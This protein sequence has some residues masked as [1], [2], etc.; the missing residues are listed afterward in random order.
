MKLLLDENL[1][2]RLLPQL[3]EV[4]PGSA[5]VRSLSLGGATDEALWSYA[6][7]HAFLLVT[8][9]EDFLSLSVRRGFPP[10]VICLAI[11]NVS[12]TV[13]ADCL[14]CN[15]KEIEWFV[16]HS[17]AGF[18]LLGLNPTQER[19]PAMGKP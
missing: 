2:E 3:Q 12:N 4:F 14:L 1:S 15:A 11:G 19:G 9:D 18:L 7:E 16:S 10:K 13:T 5:H 17:E 6:A 8:K